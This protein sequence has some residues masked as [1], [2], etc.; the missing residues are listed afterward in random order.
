MLNNMP[1]A[2][3]SL[4]RFARVSLGRFPTPVHEIALGR[5][6]C[7]WVKDDG[8]CSDLYGGNKVRKLE[9]LFADARRKGR[10]RLI[11][12]GD[13]GSHTVMASALHGRRCGFAVD[14][15][16][17]PCR[18]DA[19]A[20]AGPRRLADAGVSVTRRRHMIQVLAL[21]HILRL[22]RDS[23][24]VPLGA[25]TALTTLG[26]VRAALELCRQ[27]KEGLTP[28][29]NRIFVAHATGGTVAG[30]LIGLAMASSPAKVV[31]VQT[32]ERVIAGLRPLS[33]L[34]RQTLDTLDARDALYRPSMD[35]LERI[36]DRFLGMG[37]RDVPTAAQASV[38]RAADCGLPLEA[39][40]TGK[41][42]AALLAE[43]D[44]S[45]SRTYLFWN[46]HDRHT[47]ARA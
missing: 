10:T 26:Y 37:Y 34:V 47:G 6:R 22:R 36:D 23:Y 19:E 21:A 38:K 17:F 24:L 39:V 44:A 46:T 4:D 20:Q 32:A 41:A 5:G 16:V 2:E 45:P 28:E 11:V 1:T 27:V 43:S 29:P 40:F 12:H 9:Y 33:R 14:A 25:S 18:E 42:M 3:T 8:A 15:V 7:V 31:A 13:T 30:L 35:R